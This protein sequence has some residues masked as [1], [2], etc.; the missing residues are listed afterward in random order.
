MRMCF[1][2]D[3][4]ALHESILGVGASTGCPGVPCLT[5]SLACYVPLPLWLSA[6]CPR[7]GHDRQCNDGQRLRPDLAVALRQAGCS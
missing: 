7:P 3:W 5:A 4:A 6:V 1:S 2:N